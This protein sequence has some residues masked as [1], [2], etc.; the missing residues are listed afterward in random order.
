MMQPETVSNDIRQIFESELNLKHSHVKGNEL[1]ALCINPAHNDTHASNFSI[2]LSTGQAHCFAC[3]FSGNIVT[4][5][6]EYGISYEKA[7]RLWQVTQENS[8]KEFIIPDYTVDKWLINNYKSLGQS[9]YALDRIGD[10]KIL[11]LYN[12]W[13]DKNNNPIFLSQDLFGNYKSIWVRENNRYFL[14]EPLQAKQFGD[15]YG[16]HLPPTEYTILV[17]GHFDAPMVYKNS[18]LKTVSGFGTMLTNGQLAILKRLAPI[19][20]LL[21]GDKAGKLARNLLHDKLTGIE[22]YFCG[23]YLGDPDELSK[24]IL[25]DILAKKK[26]WLEYADWRNK[27]A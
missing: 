7:I 5:L 10:P 1:W 14:I 15:L 23:G 19:I 4:I 21:D 16:A 18:G 9:K 24:E 20:V 6:T 17:E 11:E 8:T 3:G 2:N 13:A 25:L 12:I 22:S 26:S 27:Y